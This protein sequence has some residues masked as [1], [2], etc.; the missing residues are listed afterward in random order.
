MMR[1]TELL[2]KLSKL[3]V[4]TTPPL[5]DPPGRDDVDL[6]VISSKQSC[7]AYARHQNNNWELNHPTTA[8][9][10]LEWLESQP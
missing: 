2:E 5:D 8:V 3:Y 6:M 7:E 4:C 1:N 9:P 10:L